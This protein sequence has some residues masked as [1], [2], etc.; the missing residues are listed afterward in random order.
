M[1]KEEVENLFLKLS[2]FNDKISIIYIENFADL[3]MLIK[4]KN[5]VL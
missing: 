5:I 4:T 1:G 2:L 3:V